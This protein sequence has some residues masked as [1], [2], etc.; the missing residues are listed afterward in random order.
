MTT[1]SRITR[2]LVASEQRRYFEEKNRLKEARDALKRIDA[3]GKSRLRAFDILAAACKKRHEGVQSSCLYEDVEQALS[4]EEQAAKWAR[5]LEEI[6]AK[7]NAA[8]SDK[9]KS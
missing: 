2:A 7:Q 9:V 8:V 6:G 4:P 5:R 1:K 3:E